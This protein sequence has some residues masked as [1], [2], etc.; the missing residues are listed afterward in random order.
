MQDLSKRYIIFGVLLGFALI[1]NLL[2]YN[3]I[4]DLEER[5][6]VLDNMQQ[7]VQNV[8]YSVENISSDLHMQ[9]DE[10][11]QEQLWIPEKEFQT[12]DVDIDNNTINVTVKWSMRDLLQEEKVAF[13]YREENDIEWTEL[14]V[15]HTS[16]L[17]YSLEHSFPLRGNY[18]T[19]V[20]ATSDDGKRSEDLLRLNF[21]E[22][23]E[24]RIMIDAFLHPVAQG[25]FDMN[26]DIS[27]PLG[28]ESML[29]GE[30][31]DFRMKS[32]RAFVSVDGEVIKEIDLLKDN[33]N[34]RSDPY[35]EGIFYQDFLSLEDKIGK[36]EGSVELRVVVEDELGLKYETETSM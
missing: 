17:N 34:F 13:L 1:F 33:E 10:F 35:N 16:G 6:H 14:E 18:E 22:Q 12:A 25:E 28:K 29:A 2:S 8:S 9:M 21:K 32:A 30:K 20:I 11:L 36:S 19:Q 7:D 4:S 27:N 26:I 15:T 23:L 31:D 5:L 3:K 24:N